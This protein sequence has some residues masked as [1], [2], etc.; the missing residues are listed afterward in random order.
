MKMYFVDSL[1]TGAKVVTMS[2][3]MPHFPQGI[4]RVFSAKREKYNEFFCENQ[5]FYVSQTSRAGCYRWWHSPRFSSDEM[6][7]SLWQF[8]YKRPSGV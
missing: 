7:L 8:G 6:K 3:F 4:G 1:P 2:R 5:E